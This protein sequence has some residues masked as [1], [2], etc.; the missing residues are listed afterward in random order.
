[1]RSAGTF[2]D[3]RDYD[4]EYCVDLAHLSAFLNTTQPDVAEAL[5]L[6]HDG[7]TA[8]KIPGTPSRRGHKGAAPSTCCAAA[9]STGRI[10]S[11]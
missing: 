10:R 1:M 3:P 6:D 11:I 9:S 2:G 7:P 5:D 8:A 4:R